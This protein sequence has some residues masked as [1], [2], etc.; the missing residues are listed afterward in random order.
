M[1]TDRNLLFGV[2]IL[3]LDLIDSVQ[4]DLHARHRRHWTG[5]VS[6]RRNP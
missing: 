4:F 5:L 1:D 6:S 3:Q 2:L